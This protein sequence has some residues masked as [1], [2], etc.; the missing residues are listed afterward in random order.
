ML[1]PPRLR[2]ER[3]IRGVLADRLS[4]GATDVVD[5]A[6]MARS[7]NLERIRC[8][9]SVYLLTACHHGTH[10]AAGQPDLATIGGR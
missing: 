3:A 9:G 1:D 5:R 6:L 2:I 10:S 8:G 4:R 7:E